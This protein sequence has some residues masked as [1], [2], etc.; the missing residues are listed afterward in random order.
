[1]KT[2][3]TRPLLLRTAAVV[4]TAPLL[5]AALAFRPDI[6]KEKLLDP[7]ADHPS[8]FAEIRT[9]EGDILE[10]HYRDQGSGT[11]TPLVLIHG[12]FASLHTWEGW[13]RE[14]G[15]TH[16]IITLDL[17]GFGL[18]GPD[19]S[20][21]YSTDRTVML[22]HRFLEEIGAFETDSAILPGTIHIGGNSLGG[23]IAWN[24]ALRYPQQCSSLILVNAAGYRDPDRRSPLVFTL[25]AGVADGPAGLILS[26]LTPRFLYK[27]NLEEVYGDPGRIDPALVERYYRLNRREGNREAF[28]K[29][30]LLQEPDRSAEIAELE[31]PTLILWGDRDR[32]IP[33]EHAYRFHRDIKGSELVIFPDAGHVPMEEIPLESAAAVRSFLAGL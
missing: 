29:R 14:L 8:Q 3:N 20:D 27:T 32:W 23:R 21:D 26:R 9:P 15:D 11:G 22:V 25:A 6:P 2:R 24:W 31:L 18:T 30:T 7:W 4:L 33:P 16:R 1:M 17:P 12:T 13:I 5:L 28:L 10:I 19:P